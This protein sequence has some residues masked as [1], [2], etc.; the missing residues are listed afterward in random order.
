MTKAELLKA[1]EIR[2]EIDKLEDFIW[3]AEKTWTGK[4]IKQTSRYI[5][6]SNAY[7]TMESAEYELD[8][9]MKNKVLDLLRERLKELYSE[10]E[11][12]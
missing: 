12:I 9:K 5:F 10:L 8:N 1:N 2:S 7:G 4:I 11:R 3:Q 6:K